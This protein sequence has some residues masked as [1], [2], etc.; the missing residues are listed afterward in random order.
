MAAETFSSSVI[1]KTI[2]QERRSQKVARKAAVGTLNP[3]QMRRALL[4]GEIDPFSAVLWGTNAKG[5]LFSLQDIQGF[6]DARKKVQKTFKPKQGA[7]IVQLLAASLHEDVQLSNQQIRNPNLFAIN[8][9][10]L[11]FNVPSSGATPG[12]PPY[13][14]VRIRLDEWNDQLIN[15]TDYKESVRAAL[16]GHVSIDCTCGRYQ[17]WFRYV[18]TAA[19]VAL[20][21]FEK[22]FPKIRNP[23]LL[24]MCCKHQLK[25][26]KTL[27]SPTVA[28]F[29]ENKM[30]KQATA[31]GFA[32]ESKHQTLSQKEMAQVAKARPRAIDQAKYKD[33]LK[34]LENASRVYKKKTKGEQKDRDYI[35][36]LEREKAKIVAQ[37]KKAN[38]DLERQKAAA[39]ASAKQQINKPKPK[40]DAGNEV[41][42]AGLKREIGNAKRYGGKRSDAIRFFAQERGISIDKANELARSIE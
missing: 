32:G 10:V 5:N 18:A 35:K 22:D 37:L 7:P 2:A 1:A 13:Y 16:R 4:K 9:G 6:G 12:A 19:K 36:Q 23:K 30:S 31:V 8:G 14:G 25:T 41:L 38:G 29:L 42:I 34:K 33:Q 11:H 40:P 17:Y 3:D 39:R 15:T 27:L 26:L 20:T 28:K 24:G 21:P